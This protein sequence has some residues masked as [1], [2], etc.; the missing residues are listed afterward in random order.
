[1]RKDEM[2]VC[3]TEVLANH[4]ASPLAKVLGLGMALVAASCSSEPPKVAYM[5]PFPRDGG[6]TKGGTI[7]LPDLGTPEVQSDAVPLPEPGVVDA[8]S[9][10]TASIPPVGIDAGVDGPSD[11]SRD[12]TPTDR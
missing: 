12:A 5:G 3:A 9:L 1:M 4:G 11:A 10:D 7:Q 8:A 2:E 6:D